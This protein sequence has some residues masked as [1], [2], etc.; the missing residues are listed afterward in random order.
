MLWGVMI[1]CGKSAESGHYK[2]C[3]KVGDNWVEFNDRRTS[4]ISE[5]KIKEYKEKG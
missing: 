1:H 2:L 5:A 3:I 4:V